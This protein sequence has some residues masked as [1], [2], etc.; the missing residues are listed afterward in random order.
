MGDHGVLFHCFG[1]S[2]L[3]LKQKQY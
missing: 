2:H 1:K 3:M